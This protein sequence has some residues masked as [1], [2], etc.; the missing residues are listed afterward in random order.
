MQNCSTFS[1]WW[2]R[3]MP[4][5]SRPW[6]PAWFKGQR[7]KRL[8]RRREWNK[9]ERIVVGIPM[10]LF[11]PSKDSVFCEGGYQVATKCERIPLCESRSSIP[12]T[13]EVMRQSPSTLFDAVHR[14]AVQRWQSN[15]YRLPR[16]SPV[17]RSLFPQ[18]RNQRGSAGTTI[19]HKSTSSL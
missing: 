10:F 15:I 19:Q 7:Q 13:C 11:P 2:T 12:Q 3:K 5:V 18:T 16:L 1:N 6:E 17:F 8:S 4:A 14:S 9:V